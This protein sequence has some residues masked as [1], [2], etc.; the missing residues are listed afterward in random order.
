MKV[1]RINQGRYRRDVPWSKQA[2]ATVLVK[3]DET[4]V[5]FGRRGLVSGG[6]ED[7]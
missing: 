3:L 2:S 7:A 4:M 1:W 5:S 6:I